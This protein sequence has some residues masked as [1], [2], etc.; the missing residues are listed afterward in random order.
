ME[1]IDQFGH[2]N[3]K[4]KKDEKAIPLPRIEIRCLF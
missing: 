4:G 3:K 1:I 2:A